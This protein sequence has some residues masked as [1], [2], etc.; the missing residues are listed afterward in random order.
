LTTSGKPCKKN[1]SPLSDASEPPPQAALNSCD[2]AD[3]TPSKIMQHFSLLS[4]FSKMIRHQQV[5]LTGLHI[6]SDLLT[7]HSDQPPFL[8]HMDVYQII[9]AIPIGGVPW[10]SFTVTYEGPKPISDIPKWMDTEY[11]VW[12]RDPHQLFLQIL[13]N[14]EFANSFDYAPY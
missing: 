10:Q 3:W 4:I 7:V 9:D 12:F 13:K 11:T 6:V 1:G 14:P 8:D 2:P 5:I